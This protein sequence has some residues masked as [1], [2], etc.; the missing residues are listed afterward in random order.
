MA[1]TPPDTYGAVWKAYSRV[2]DLALN[3]QLRRSRRIRRRLRTSLAQLR[4]IVENLV[5][6]LPEQILH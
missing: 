2:G 5:E 4:R 3:G 6:R 1:I